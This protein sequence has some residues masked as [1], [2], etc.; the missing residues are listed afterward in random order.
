[1]RAMDGGAPGRG[2]FK[3]GEERVASSIGREFSYKYSLP[4]DPTQPGARF[5]YTNHTE[6]GTF[7]LTALTWFSPTYSRGSNAAPGDTDTV[8]FGGFGRWSQDPD[9]HQ[10]SVHIS[11]ADGAHYVGI[12]VD[13][14]V[15]SNVNTK[16]AD[17]RETM[18]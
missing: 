18:P 17:I 13:G 10:V 1:M 5:E 9:L 15:T 8:T 12:Q 7:T 3:G 2:T 16:P 14:G 4:L 11:K 6:G